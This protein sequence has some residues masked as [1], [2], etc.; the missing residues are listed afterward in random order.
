[1][2]VK[3]TKSPLAA[4][5]AGVFILSACATNQDG[6]YKYDARAT[7][8][9]IGALTG[10]ALGA[11]THGG[12]GC[13][14]GAVVGA[15]AGFLIG[16]YFESKKTS[17]AEQ[18]NAEYENGTRNRSISVEPPKDSIVPAK[19]DTKVSTGQADS[20]GQREIQVTSNTDLIGYGDRVPEVEQRYAIY[21][22][23]NNLLEEKT[24]KLTSVDGAGRYQT[25]SKF[26]LPAESKGKSYTVKTTLVTNQ[27]EYKENTYKVTLNE[28]QPTQ[29]AL[30]Y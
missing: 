13:A 22:E 12:K 23:K 29:L 11:A 8:A 20:S 6:S 1:M 19:F 28:S 26:K 18:V 21:D 15:A 5:L 16:W 3:C 30:I 7:G 25:N 27:K 9:L 2:N 24:E 4:A 10:C 14:T 17:T